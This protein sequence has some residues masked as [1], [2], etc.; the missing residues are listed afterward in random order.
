[1][2][3][4]KTRRPIYRQKFAG[5]TIT[6]QH[7]GKPGYAAVA[8]MRKDGKRVREKYCATVAEAKPLAEGWAI[9]AGNL[10]ARAVS[11]ITDDEKRFLLEVRTKLAPLGRTIKDAF[12]HYWSHLERTKVS[13]PV[14][15]LV[16]HF[17]T[18]KTKERAG[19]RHLKDIR[20]RL[21]KFSERFGD[22]IAGGI[23]TEDISDWLAGLNLAPQSTVN[24]RR[25]LHNLFAFA[26]TLGAVPKNPVSNALRPRVRRGRVGILTV[27]EVEAIL[28]ALQ[29]EPEIRP[30]IL[31]GLFA[32]IRDAELRRLKWKDVDL[33]SGFITV[34]ASDAKTQRR[35]LVPIRPVLAALLGKAGEGT[36][37]PRKP[38]RGTYLWKL[39]RR[40]AGFGT[41]GSE[42]DE[43][44]QAGLTLK[45]WHDNA[46]RHT[47]ASYHIA[48]FQD[49]PKLALE[50]GNSVPVIME[51][52][53]ELVLPAE[54]EKFWSLTPGTVDMPQET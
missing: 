3:Q 53:R 31:L 34:N 25:V 47:F 24:Y 37:W 18:F 49:A 33:K 40:R 42:T 19:D 4:P 44:K 15:D 1:M 54:A 10:G 26:V 21:K 29:K 6:V 2:T 32:G 11:E 13:I 14:K 17:M 39:V 46:L 30:A 45:P 5:I 23:S 35:R 36:I 51:H 48:K 27:E 22:S 16:E 38:Q 43:E 8:L 20:L 41:P 12:D 52:Y 7:S 28:A 9:E 50:L